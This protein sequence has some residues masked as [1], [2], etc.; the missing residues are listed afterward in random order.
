[1]YKMCAFN[2]KLFTIRIFIRESD[3]PFK[4]L[5]NNTNKIQ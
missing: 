3:F 5:N 1:M 4:I 2:T